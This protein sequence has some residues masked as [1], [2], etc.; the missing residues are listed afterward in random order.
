M[1]VCGGGGGDQL[2]KNDGWWGQDK[3]QIDEWWGLMQIFIDGALFLK[4]ASH[5]PSPD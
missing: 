3:I 5:P 2:L 1:C 4:S